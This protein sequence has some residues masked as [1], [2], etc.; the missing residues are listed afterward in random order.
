MKYQRTKLLLTS[1]A[2]LFLAMGTA[3]ASGDYKCGPTITVDTYCAA[4]HRHYEFLDKDCWK[5]WKK[6]PANS[7]EIS[8]RTFLGTRNL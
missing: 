7:F 8:G 6:R 4:N 5:E 3:H 1:I 2:A